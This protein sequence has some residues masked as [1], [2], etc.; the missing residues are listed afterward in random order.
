MSVCKGQK[1]VGCGPRTALPVP[2]LHAMR[3]GRK[4]QRVQGC[5]TRDRN[6][7]GWNDKTPHPQDDSNNCEGNSSS[8]LT[9]RGEW[10][11]RQPSEDMGDKADDGNELQAAGVK[12]A[13]LE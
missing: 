6:D 12:G 3:T 1:A 8:G 9:K 4:E 7:P 5:R 13:C 11:A 10:P 2:N